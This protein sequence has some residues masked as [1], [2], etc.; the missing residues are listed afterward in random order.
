M[1]RSKTQVGLSQKI[2]CVCV[3]R[4][5]LRTRN[6]SFAKSAHMV[7]AYF[8]ST[9]SHRFVIVSQPRHAP[10]L[11]HSADPCAYTELSLEQ[12]LPLNF[13]PKDLGVSETAMSSEKKYRIVCHDMRRYVVGSDKQ[14]ASGRESK[15]A[16]TNMACCLPASQPCCVASSS[17]SS[18]HDPVP[19]SSSSFPNP[20][21]KQ[22]TLNPHLDLA[23][24]ACVQS[25]VR[26]SEMA[27]CPYSRAPAG[28][29]VQTRDGSLYAGR[30]V[31]NAAFN[32]ST[33]PMRDALNLAVLHGASIEDVTCVVLV[34]AC[35]APPSAALSPSGCVPSP[36]CAASSPASSSSSSSS[37][38]CVP[39]IAKACKCMAS[40]PMRPVSHTDQFLAL[41]RP[42]LPAGCELVVAQATRQCTCQV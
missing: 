28:A 3:R 23:Q 19:P 33:I 31:E 14:D 37:S 32:P 1:L 8:S 5:F 24:D 7:Q 35:A 9:L 4:L 6:T 40:T 41:L 16:D 36:L 13:G 27:Y 11:L 29:C 10:V 26:Q 12:L 17:S 15:H 39:V 30:Y 21:T 34:Q 25:A 2:V 18:P 20:H 42:L 22:G 38:V